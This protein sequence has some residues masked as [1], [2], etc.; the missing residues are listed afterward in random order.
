[1][2]RTGRLYIDLYGENQHDSRQPHHICTVSYTLLSFLSALRFLLLPLIL[3]LSISS[4]CKQWC[5]FLRRKSIMSQRPPAHSDSMESPDPEHEAPKKAKSRRPASK[6]TLPLPLRH[7]RPTYLDT[8]TDTPRYCLPATTT[9][10]M[11]VRPQ[12]FSCSITPLP[13]LIFNL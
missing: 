10:S 12:P 3:I 13:G 4:E 1:M 6:T 9:Q 2:I 8:N 5:H 7:I 11:A